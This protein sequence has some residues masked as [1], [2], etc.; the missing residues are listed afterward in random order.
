MSKIKFGVQIPPDP[1]DNSKGQT[2]VNKIT[3]FLDNLDTKYETAWLADHLIPTIDMYPNNKPQNITKD[4]HECLTTASYLLPLYPKLKIGTLV[5]SNN[6]RNPALLA[7]MTSTLQTLSNGRFILGIGAGWYEREY[8]QYGYKYPSNRTRIKQLE[9]AVQIIRLMWEKDGVT[10]HG[11]YHQ[12][13]DA[14]C[15]P[16]PDP[17]PPIMIGGG[18]EKLTLKVV[19]KYAD[20]WN[21]GLH[22]VDLWSRRLNILADYCDDIGRSVD[23]IVKSNLWAVSVAG[24]YDEALSLAKRS[25]YYADWSFIVGTPDQVASKLGELIDVG[26]DYFQISFPQLQINETAQLFADEVIPNL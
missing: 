22:G 25:Q 17:A 15:N 9:E 11:K 23:D 10:F 12:I 5:L 19:A 20:W 1:E 18:G 6:Y 26:V 16:K 2:F 14:Y 21:V 24:S 7:K 4:N 3:D 13:E 8:K